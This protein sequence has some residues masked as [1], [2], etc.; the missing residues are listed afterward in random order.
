[1]NDDALNK[2]FSLAKNEPLTTHVNDVDR[3]ITDAV[4]IGFWAGIL[5]HIKL[6]VIKKTILMSIVTTALTVGTIVA[7]ALF[8]S[9]E[10]LK[11]KH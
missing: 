3:W 1:M 8:S 9:K 2:L 7:V 4:K 6:L 10:T 11:K 5:Y